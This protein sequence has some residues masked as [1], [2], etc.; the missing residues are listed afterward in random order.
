MALA[1]FFISFKLRTIKCRSK[2]Q[3]K[4][5]QFNFIFCKAVVIKRKLSVSWC[6]QFSHEMIKF[7]LAA[8]ASFTTP[9]KIVISHENYLILYCHGNDDDGEGRF[10]KFIGSNMLD[11]HSQSK[12]V[13]F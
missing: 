11:V 12:L 4:F 1:G 3:T 5:V 8:T 9:K 2:S 7:F 13:L 6:H 10:L